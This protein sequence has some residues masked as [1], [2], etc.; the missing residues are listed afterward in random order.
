MR[1]FVVI[2]VVV[3]AAMPLLVSNAKDR[4][5]RQVDRDGSSFE[6]AIIVPPHQPNEVEWEFKQ[7][8]RLYP[9]AEIVPV[10]QALASHRGRDYDLWTLKTPR[11]KVT[12]YFDI[13]E[14]D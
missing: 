5:K 9:D 12:M 10:E 4:K 8:R 1:R 2:G 7:M 11:G 6:R 3:C 14:H 13:T